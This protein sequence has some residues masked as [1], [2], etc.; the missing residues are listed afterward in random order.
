MITIYVHEWIIVSSRKEKTN[1]VECLNKTFQMKDM[2]ELH[3]FLGIEVH[4]N[5]AKGQ[6][7]L[8]HHRY[9]AG[10]LAK[11]GVTNCRVAPTPMSTGCHKNLCR[12]SRMHCIV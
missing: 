1:I 3:Y 7:V 8:S 6:M 4:M 2:G 10:V 11:F 9:S 12:Q 5:R